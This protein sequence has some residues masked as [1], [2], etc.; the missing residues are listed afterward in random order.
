[1]K[2]QEEKESQESMG[3]KIP[4]ITCRGMC[5]LQKLKKGVFLKTDKPVIE[6]QKLKK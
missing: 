1:M 6:L 2:T 5:Q 4:K 3:T